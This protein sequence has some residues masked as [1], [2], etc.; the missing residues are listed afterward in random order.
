[1]LWHIAQHAP[2]LRRWLIANPRA[3]ATLLEFISQAG[4]PEVK[5]ALA[6]L[7]E[8]MEEE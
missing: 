8:S 7:L 3:D 1:M 6:V 4:G 5:R 2:E